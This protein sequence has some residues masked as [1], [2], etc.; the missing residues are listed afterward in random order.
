M[1]PLVEPELARE[2]D[3]AVKIMAKSLFRDLRQ[4][5]YSSRQIVALTTELIDLVTGDLRV[6]TK[7]GNES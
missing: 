4:A 5:G 1:A 2:R 6:D 3:K 7:D